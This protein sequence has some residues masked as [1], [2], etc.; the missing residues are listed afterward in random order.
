MNQYGLKVKGLKAGRYEIR[1]GGK[2]VAE[3][4][5]AELAAGVNLATAALTTG[6]VAEQVNEVWQAVV[7]KNRY[8]HDRI[9]RGVVLAQVSIPDFLDIKVSDVE[10]KRKAAFEERMKKMPELDAAVRKA[11]VV[12]PHQVDIVPV[13]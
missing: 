4:T 11:L 12:K 2:K 6:P 1:L 9:F 10:A 5:A 7:A 8:F 3:H 13:K